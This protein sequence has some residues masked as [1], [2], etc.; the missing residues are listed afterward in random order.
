M[1]KMKHLNAICLAAATA[2]ILFAAGCHGDDDKMDR[3]RVD[4]LE[5]TQEAAGARTEATLY[6]QHFDGDQLTSLGAEELDLMLADSH[7]TNPLVVYID[8]PEDD[9]SEAR[10]MAVGK[11]L[12]AHGNLTAEQIEFRSGAN[13][14]TYAPAGIQLS[15]YGKTDT[16]DA[17]GS[18]AA[19]GT[20]H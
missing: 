7:S 8:V 3:A 11:Y 6:P 16:S 19:A 17:G 12:E 20:S 5:H 14:A 10:R 15:N 1:L 2:T 13:P 9:H 4:R 18:S